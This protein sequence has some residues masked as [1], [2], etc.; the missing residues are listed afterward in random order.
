[1]NWDQIEGQWHE[2]MG[3]VKTRW[4]RLTDNDLANVSGKKE[5]LVGAIQ[6]RYG[7][8]KEAADRQVDDWI[9]RARMPGHRQE[10]LKKMPLS[11]HHH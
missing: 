10:P 3:R 7:I 8:A 9:T 4:A 5:S 2:M 1:M 11:R 6:Q